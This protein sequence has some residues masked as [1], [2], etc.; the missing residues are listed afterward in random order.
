MNLEIHS[1]SEP[2]KDFVSNMLGLNRDL[3]EGLT[4]ESREWREKTNEFLTSTFAGKGV[5]HSDIEVSPRLLL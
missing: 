1:P 3:L 4:P 5:F 2:L